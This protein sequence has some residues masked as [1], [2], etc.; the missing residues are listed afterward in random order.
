MNEFIGYLIVGSMCCFGVYK[1]FDDLLINV[2]AWFELKIGVKACKP[3]FSCPPCM[4]SVHGLYLGIIF[5]GLDHMVL[6]YCIALCGLNY[7]VN[8]LLPKYE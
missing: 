4:G 8:E 3:L 1:I 7:I 5:L 6:L 2:R